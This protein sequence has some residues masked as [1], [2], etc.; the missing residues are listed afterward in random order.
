VRHW[1]QYT[2]RVPVLLA[3]LGMLVVSLDSAVNVALPAM[4]EAFAIGP[5]EIRWVIICYVLTYAITSVAAGVVAD[6]LGPVPVY[7]AGMWL[8]VVAFL[9]YFLVT[10]YP[11]MLATRVA[12]GLAGGLVYGTSP[13]LITLSLPRERH[14]RGLGMLAAG[15]GV[16]GIAGPLVGGVIVAW[17]WPWVF[18]FRVPLAL[19]AGL[20]APWLLPRI[21]GAGVWS[22]PPRREWTTWPVMQ[23]LTLAAMASWAQFSV[24]LLASFYLVS[25]RGLSA[26]AGGLL[27]VLSPFGAAVGGPVAGWMTDRIGRRRPMILGLLLEAAGLGMLGLA[28]RTT[29]LHAVA[30]ALFLVGFGVGSFQVPN[31]AQVM[32]A[33]PR[34]RQGT[35]GGL[36]HLGRTLGVVAGVQAAATVY[37]SLQTTL[38][39]AVAFRAAFGA[40][41]VICLLAIVLALVPGPRTARPRAGEGLG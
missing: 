14:G 35:A 2:R 10:D 36:A 25:L 9:L 7:T 37:G 26:A 33:F 6:R 30:L 15:Q 12:Q 16:G 8:S 22:L 24:W 28:D 31:L 5:A 3:A 20:L 32:L 29:P 34:A 4:A 13:A 38:G 19:A 40:A 21:A 39:S 18:V 11:L 23:G 17:G 27:F 41:A 1:L